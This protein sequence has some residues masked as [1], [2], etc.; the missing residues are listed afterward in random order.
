MRGVAKCFHWL[1]CQ[2]GQDR[3]RFLLYRAQSCIP[4]LCCLRE[5][6]FYTPSVLVSLGW[7]VLLGFSLEWDDLLI[8]AQIFRH[9]DCL[10]LLQQGRGRTLYNLSYVGSLREACF[11]FSEKCR[12]V[13]MASQ[14]CKVMVLATQ[15]TFV[16]DF[17]YIRHPGSP[18][19]D[20]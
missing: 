14:R 9:W 20:M 7:I 8:H 16:A 18:N 12:F 1:Q 13:L 15:S 4:C 5:Q 6:T 17:Q 3:G 10:K 11:V 19:I 2:G